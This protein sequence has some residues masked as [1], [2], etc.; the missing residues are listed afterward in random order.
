[1]LQG[2]TGSAR[3]ERVTGSAL[4]LVVQMDS[5]SLKISTYTAG[6]HNQ[7]LEMQLSTIQRVY[8]AKPHTNFDFHWVPP[9]VCETFDKW[10]ALAAY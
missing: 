1:M 4:W 2:S 6:F 7:L 10:L 5:I 3:Q 9:T 8:Q